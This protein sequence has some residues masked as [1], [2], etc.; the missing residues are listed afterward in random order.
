MKIAAQYGFEAAHQL[1]RLPEGHKCK[2]LHGHN[3]KIEV[4]VEGEPDA[5]GFVMD[6]A[7]L[8]AIVQPIIDRI[9][10]RYLNDIDGLE[11]PTSEVLVM[12]LR[13]RIAA[14]VKLPFTVRIY[15]TPRY[16]VEA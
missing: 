4:V 5:R 8:D 1:P 11:N 7:E 10:H 15:E 14:D 12:W 3:Y 2:R 13:D 16:W 9:D 6:Y